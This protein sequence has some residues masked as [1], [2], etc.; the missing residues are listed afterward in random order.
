MRFFLDYVATQRKSPL[1]LEAIRL[2]SPHERH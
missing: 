1:L 2:A